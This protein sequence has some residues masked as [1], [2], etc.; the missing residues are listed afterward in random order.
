MNAI[1]SSQQQLQYIQ[2]FLIK[3]ADGDY[4]STLPVID[5]KDEQLLA[6]QVGINMLVEELKESTISRV[7]LDSIYNGINDVLIVLNATGEIQNTN[8]VTH[9]LLSYSEDELKNKNIDILIQ[10]NDRDAVKNAIRDAFEQQKT[11]EVAINIITKEEN[12]ISSACTISP[13]LDAKKNITGALMVAKNMSTL[14]TAKNQLR[15]KN[16]EL[17]LF[18]YKASHDLKS[19]I[20][21]MM[22]VMTLLNNCNNLEEIQLYTKMINECINKLNVVISDLL[23]LGQINHKALEYEKI[24]L[25]EIIQ[26]I[27]ESIEFI[28][29]FNDV[30][31]EIEINPEA[32][33]I[34]TEK[35]LLRTILLNLIDN[36]IKYKNKSAELSFLKIRILPEKKGISIQVEDNGIGIPENQQ[37]KI[38]KMFYRATSTSKGSGLGLYIVRTS[39]IKLGG[40]ISLSSAL[41]VGTT[42]KIYIPEMKEVN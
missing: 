27:I 19:P 15:D 32:K 42:F 40:T 41:N 8:N 13:L 1:K 39:V 36:G 11:Q 21:S 35:G 3:I 24:N 22:S 5:E 2:D 4:N 34:N 18:V 30:K 29:D 23:V 12:T 17:N 10:L 14:I 38:F 7:F 28:K 16:E 6:I 31:I 37:D 20:S 26:G 25:E 9:Q 33:Y